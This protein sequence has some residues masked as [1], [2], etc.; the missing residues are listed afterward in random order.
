MKIETE[1]EIFMRTPTWYWGEGVSN[2]YY[3]VGGTYVWV[4]P[5][6]KTW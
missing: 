4:F 5:A 2:C 3:Y 1:E 6:I